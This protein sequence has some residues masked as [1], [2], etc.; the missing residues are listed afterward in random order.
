M[1]RKR[2]GRNE[3]SIHKRKDGTYEAK[4]SLGYDA[5]GKRIRPTVYGKTKKEVMEKLEELKQDVSLGVPVAP[6]K[7]T[8]KQYFETWLAERSSYIKPTTSSKDSYHTDHI[9]AKLGHI[10]L[11]DLDY[12]HIIAFYNELD[13]TLSDRTIFDISTTFRKAL[14]DAVNKKILRDNQ[15]LLVKRPRGDK[16]ARCMTQ[17]ELTTVLKAA[18][19]ERLYEAFIVLANTG[20]RPGEWLGLS[21]DDIDFT[22][23]TLTVRRSLHELATIKEEQLRLYLGEPKTKAAKRTITLPKSAVEA[24]KTWKIKQNKER[25]EAGSNWNNEYTLI[26][27]NTLG[28]FLSRNNIVKRDLR[29]ILNKAAIFRAAQRLKVDAEKTL[30]LNTP[31]LPARKVE[32]G[33]YFVLPN[34][35]QAVLTKKDIFAGVALHTFR[36]THVSLLIAAGVDIK[37]ISKRIGHERI[38]I[39]YDLYGHILPGMDKVAADSMDVFMQKINL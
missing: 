2:R 28:K 36:H 11:Q 24:L 21:W 35:K 14:G 26:F 12:R 27:T 1:A 9:V 6:E 32:V 25:L 20:L 3:G 37:T 30:E 22:K 23:N 4:I 33:D 29:R 16:E 5:E 18:Q 13:K 19:G 10:K 38:S 39:T 8:V 15:A 31:Y 7:I 17:D 34:N